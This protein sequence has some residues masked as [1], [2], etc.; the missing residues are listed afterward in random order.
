MATT[1]FILQIPKGFIY[2]HNWVLFVFFASF[3]LG[4]SP[5]YRISEYYFHLFAISF[6]SSFCYLLNVPAVLDLY[7][8]KNFFVILYVSSLPISTRNCLCFYNGF[9]FET[10]FFQ[11][12]FFCVHW[13]PNNE[14]LQYFI[15][16]LTFCTV[17]MFIFLSFLYRVN[18]FS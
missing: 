7:W 5:L 16:F 6:C 1:I 18:D 12:L 9:Y 15:S 2:S 10:N 13:Y 17:Q 11:L 14:I 3:S 4:V 8:P